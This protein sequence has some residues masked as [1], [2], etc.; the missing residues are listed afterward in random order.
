M[1]QNGCFHWATRLQMV[2]CF[3]SIVMIAYSLFSLVRITRN[4]IDLT[5]SEEANDSDFFGL[6]LKN[7]DIFGN[8]MAV[9]IVSILLLYGN[10]STPPSFYLTFIILNAFVIFH[11]LLKTIY[12]QF[13]GNFQVNNQ[14]FCLTTFVVQII[15]VAIVWLARSEALTMRKYTTNSMDSKAQLFLYDNTIP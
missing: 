10:L 8:T 9:F 2:V 4:F 5:N 7:V 15:F 14:F 3:I 1:R 11:W 13:N 6:L 12:A